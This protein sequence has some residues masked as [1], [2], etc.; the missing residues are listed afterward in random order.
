MDSI[1][2]TRY[3]Y[4]YNDVL[5]SLE[6]AILAKQRDESLFW[7]YELYWSGYQ[8]EVID[9]LLKITSIHYSKTYTKLVE[10]MT[11]LSKEWNG[12]NYEVIA[13]MVNNL[14]IRDIEK[15][16]TIFYVRCIKQTAD[17][18]NTQ[19]KTNY[20]HLEKVSRFSIR[21]KQKQ[22]IN[23]EYLYDWLYYAAKCPL[24]KSRIEKYEGKLNHQKCEV[25]FSDDDLLEEFYELYGLEPDEQSKKVHEKRGVYLMQ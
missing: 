12:D 7:A 2:F 17:K 3:L 13:S 9:W 5:E 23:R 21:N 16:S 14:V 6:L 10:F 18:Y 15:V 8:K 25:V 1:V 20:K 4:N 11:T 24:W 19:E 22:N